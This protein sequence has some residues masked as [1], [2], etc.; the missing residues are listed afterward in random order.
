[1]EEWARLQLA[2]KPV[3]GVEHEDVVHQVILKVQRN[4]TYDPSK[5][6]LEAWLFTA[7]RNE[8]T[9]A[10]RRM[11][12]HPGGV[13][14]GTADGDRLPP[15][16]AQPDDTPGSDWLRHRRT[17]VR[18]ALRRMRQEVSPID[19]EVCFLWT[20]AES[21]LGVAPLSAREVA[22]KINQR[23]HPDPPMNG[24]RAWEIA[25]RVRNQIR[26][27]LVDAGIDPNEMHPETLG[28]VLREALAAGRPS[29]SEWTPEP[30]QGGQS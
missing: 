19:W 21:V 17:Q 11:R 10:V 4:W 30:E 12:R 2:R 20:M 27:A 16:P 14:A 29:S 13:G 3:P 22:E 1:M 15:I 18:E 24:R 5:G 7:I 23:F 28:V 6:P 8:I 26:Q 25:T 9:D